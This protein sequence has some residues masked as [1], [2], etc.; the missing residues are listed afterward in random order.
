MT[1]PPSMGHMTTLERT[2]EAAAT[3]YH[4]QLQDEFNVAY[5]H[6]VAYPRE[7]LT[8]L[9][10]HHGVSWNCLPGLCGGRVAQWRTWHRGPEPETIKDAVQADSQRF[11]Q[12]VNLAALAALAA[13]ADV[14]DRSLGQTGLTDTVLDR[15]AA[16]HAHRQQCGTDDI[17]GRAPDQPGRFSAALAQQW[18]LYLAFG[19]PW[20]ANTENL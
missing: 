5:Q 19:R 14:A 16:P 3:R 17:V 2:P 10:D 11:P 18:L 9:L 8:R 20:L 1:A 15:N 7:A 13:L 12:S 6:H 4:Q